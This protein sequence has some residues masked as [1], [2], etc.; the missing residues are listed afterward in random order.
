V[1]TEDDACHGAV[2]GSIVANSSGPGMVGM[3]KPGRVGWAWI[4]A[5]SLAFTLSWAGYWA[6]GIL[7]AGFG[8]AV[9]AVAGGFA[10]LLVDQ[11]RRKQDAA[12]AARDAEGLPRKYGPAHLLEPGLGVVPFTGRSNELEALEAWCSVAEGE[13]VRLVTG[14]GGT[15][16]TRLALQLCRR[17]AAQGWRWVLVGEGA[18]AHVIQRERSVAP[19]MPLLVVVD[20]AEARIGLEK[21]LE[22]AIRD[23]WG[24]RVLLLARHAGDWWQRL[25]AAGGEV[26]GVVAQA[27]QALMP[28]AGEL[29]SDLPAAEVVQQAVPAFAGRLGVPSPVAVQVVVSAKASLR[30]L[31][32]HAAAL[33]AVIQS[34][35]Q[36][37][38]PVLQVDVGTVLETLLVMR[39]ITG[40]AGRRRR[41]WWAA[42][43]G[44]AWRSCLRWWQPGACW[45]QGRSRS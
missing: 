14:G 23:A 31:D 36:P 45:A 2:R 12:Q 13:L 44:S 24:V 4:C 1:Q 17:M 22:A 19:R 16:K 34:M 5:I 41:G 30:V 10:P 25:G 43:T 33:V 7:G 18:E 35:E 39:S 15:G 37:G 20:Y 26:R 42:R 27:G 3:L 21:L 11:A 29:D 28:L 40:L 9:G 32:L 38:R 8:V 6:G